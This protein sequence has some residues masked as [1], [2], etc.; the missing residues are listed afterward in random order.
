MTFL[1]A[2]DSRFCYA[3]MPQCV[4]I[5]TKKKTNSKTLFC[6]WRREWMMMFKELERIAIILT[7]LHIKSFW[8]DCIPWF[9]SK[10][11]EIHEKKEKIL[12]GI[13]H[14][15]RVETIPMSI[16]FQRSTKHVWINE[17]EI[18]D[19]ARNTR[20]LS[21][22]Y[23]STTEQNIHSLSLNTK[24]MNEKKERENNHTHLYSAQLNH[25]FSSWNN[26]SYDKQK[27]QKLEKIY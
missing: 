6:C 5:F 9:L 2:F 25:K 16:N 7:K 26:F 22:D 18:Y 14:P 3:D 20:S 24:I 11:E 27:H 10:I 12:M 23:S 19:D 8:A 4:V 13:K 21:T 1:M 15:L 17:N